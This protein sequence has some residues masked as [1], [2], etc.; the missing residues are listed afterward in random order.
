[1]SFLPRDLR[2]AS[3][4]AQDRVADSYITLAGSLPDA[5]RYVTVLLLLPYMEGG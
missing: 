3:L 4:M 1:M 2:K 5:K